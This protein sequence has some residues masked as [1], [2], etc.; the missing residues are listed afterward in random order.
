[1]SFLDNLERKGL[2]R[3][4]RI[5]AL[6]IIGLLIL[7][8]IGGAIFF[9]STL[10][11]IDSR[12]IDP[13]KVVATIAPPPIQSSEDRSTSSASSDQNTP[14]AAN[15]FPGL[16]IPFSL[17]PYFNNAAFREF[18]TGKLSGMQLADQQDYIDNMGQVVD[19]AKVADLK[20]PD[21]IESYV[22]LKDEKIEAIAAQKTEG[23][24]TRIYLLATAGSALGL[25]GLFSL[26][27]VLLAI[28]RNTRVRAA[29]LVN[30]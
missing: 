5:L 10:I 19:A 12:H 18:M 4:T 29:E 6:L 8:V 11:P 17:Q 2:F 7:G 1:M 24:Q 9:S 26:I 16:K 22:R 15:S 21:A 28:E 13:S 20:I 23:V 3:F 25:I 14:V 30:R 27:L